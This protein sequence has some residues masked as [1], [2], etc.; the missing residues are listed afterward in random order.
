MSLQ[1]ANHVSWPSKSY[2]VASF[3]PVRGC[4]LS[5]PVSVDTNYRCA[6]S[7]GLQFCHRIS[8][9]V[10]LYCDE[11]ACQVCTVVSECMD[12]V[13]RRTSVNDIPNDESQF[14]FASRSI[15][16]SNQPECGDLP[17]T[18]YK[19][20]ARHASLS[21]LMSKMSNGIF[22][23]PLSPPTAYSFYSVKNY[24]C[25]LE[26]LSSFRVRSFTEFS[27]PFTLSSDIRPLTN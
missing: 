19:E 7:W 13:L 21:L 23:L 26:N 1:T 20:R 6:M 16:L 10:I 27:L 15:W 2:A 22:M 9:V 11:P 4:Q 18:L 25:P 14:P 5:C 3:R 24:S 12:S 8:K 17:L